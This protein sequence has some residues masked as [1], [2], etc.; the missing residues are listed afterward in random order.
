MSA[1]SES[2]FYEY[3]EEC[4]EMLDRLSHNIS[5]TEKNGFNKEIIASIYRDMHTIKGS[6]QLFGFSK[7]ANLAHTMETC[8]DPI[9]KE[10]IK[11]S[12]ELLDSIYLGINFIIIALEKL[13]ETKK[14]PELKG[15]I[16]KLF[17]KFITSI[18]LIFTKM[19]PLAKD[20]WLVSDQIP[21][22]DMGLHIVK[23]TE[24]VTENIDQKNQGFGFFDDMDKP[25]MSP[26]K[27][28][29]EKKDLVVET[30][31]QVVTINKKVE[32]TL[33][34]QEVKK[35]SLDEQVSETIRVQVSLLNSLMNLVGELVL[36]RNQLLQHAKLND[37]DAEFLK[38][39]Q[40][41][42]ILTAELQNEVMKTRMQPIGN[43]LT[44]YSRVVRDLSRELNKRIELQLI[45]IE[46][47]LDKTVIEA[48]KDPLMHIVRNAIDHGIETI[49][50]RKKAG[51]K[52]SALIQIKSYNENGQVI[53]E[54]IDDGRGLDLKRI[55]KKAIEKGII[56]T[57][58]L[59][60]MSEKE[61]QLLIF[62]PG[63]STAESISNIS[64]RGVGMDVVK[65][66][67]E[68]IGGIV[69]LFSVQ[70]AGTSIIIKI[71]LSL[72][73]LPALI[74]QSH[75]QKFAIPQTKL[76]ELLRID[77]S[78]DSN[79]KIEFL[80]GS[81]IFR[82]RG[83]LIPIISLSKV[84]F[85]KDLDLS[86]I[87]N[88]VAN[89][90]ILN[91][92]NFLFGLIVDEIDDSADIV[93]KPL[94]QFLKELKIF[95][96]ASIMGD[97][98]VALTIDVLGLAEKAQLFSEAKQEAQHTIIKSKI[99]NYYHLDV[100]EYLLI[101]VGAPNL[102][103]I[104]LSI[105]NRIEEFEDSKFEYSGEQ[106]IIRY[107]EI[108]L[109]IFSLPEFLKLTFEKKTKSEFV[110]VPI[111][112]IRRGDFYYGIEVDMVHDII[113][114]STKID[115]SVKDRPGILGSVVANEKVIVIAD[116]FGMIEQLKEKLKTGS[117]S[118]D[119]E[120]NEM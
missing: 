92:D 57:E 55:G 16:E 43:V 103:G 61:T 9:R 65:T 28:I 40:R 73:I 69:D 25:A 108:L 110:R 90:V 37:E 101:D 63:F 87:E 119:T 112:V 117:V 44:V 39:S 86:S 47:E 99:A 56:T 19:K 29:S 6:A 51:K 31:P 118:T 59:G 96:G 67:V 11:L 4:Q 113:E 49:D 18:E 78:E 84:L 98:S 27:P 85:N 3:I 76:V 46:T 80:Q 10:K 12:K 60:K 64:G 36:I 42:N 111:I 62:S 2:A 20:K 77:C 107:R 15:E 105:V 72:A 81:M 120:R 109:P 66:N 23:E 93:V 116:I 14:E 22:L 38:M 95:S 41:L 17:I 21:A 94:S 100:C 71:P 33:P 106:K 48:V 104:P 34:S 82:L 30:P 97:G 7:I 83:K 75:R 74:V 68:K 102:Y 91:A 89:V 54:I 5:L 88:N 70:G 24:K 32:E 52:E 8:L 26:E 58:Q 50:E 45:G 1:Q 114:V 115:Q 79:E 13:K 35:A 53:I